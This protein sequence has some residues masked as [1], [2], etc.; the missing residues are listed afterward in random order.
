MPVKP[1]PITK[2]PGHSN[3]YRRGGANFYAR[4]SVGRK[5]TFRSLGTSKIREAK[6][7]L[8]ELQSGHRLQADRRKE[9]TLFE[10][11]DQVLEFRKNRRGPSRPLSPRT[12]GT[13][14][15]LA[16]KARKLFPDKLLS[17]FRDDDFTVPLAEMGGSA[18][19]RKQVFELIK[20]AYRRAKS[21]GQVEINPLEGIVPDQVRRKER[22]LPSRDELD[23]ICDK[24]VELF[25]RRGKGEILASGKAA[26]LSARF[27]AYSGLRLSEAR[28]VLWKHV[29]GG[30]LEVH[31]LEGRLKTSNSRRQI[32]INAPLQE[33]LDEISAIYGSH[34]L[35]SVLP[36]ATILKFLRVSCEAL[37]LDP[38]THHDL[39]SY[40]ATLCITSGVDIN[41]T[42][43]W[44][45][46]EVTT[47]LRV[48]LQVNEETMAA[49]ASKIL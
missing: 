15:E 25:G 40:F 39:R 43:N 38:L 37:G 49:A 31:G 46:D 9:P 17:S 35:D 10:A 4:I 44:M 45:G 20:G 26:A 13:H 21:L 11:I 5:Q 48:Y 27:L 29:R 41:T 23:T 6:K 12:I 7:R 32:H 16:A 33:V 36:T 14:E 1:K 19:R 42:A 3:L 47:V 2:V 24:I 30:K 8:A 18:S 22:R 34:P 28:G